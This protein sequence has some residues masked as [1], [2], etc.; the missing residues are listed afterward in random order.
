[1]AAGVGVQLQRRWKVTQDTVELLTPRYT[2]EQTHTVPAQA[3]SVSNQ[4]LLQQMKRIDDGVLRAFVV[5]VEAV[6]RFV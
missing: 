4:H 3:A 5:F 1:M 2:E 6:E